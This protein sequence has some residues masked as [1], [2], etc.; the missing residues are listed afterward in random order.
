MITVRALSN[1]LLFWKMFVI[2]HCNGSG[3]RCLREGCVTSLLEKLFGGRPGAVNAIPW[4]RS[5]HGD[6]AKGKSLND[7]SLVDWLHGM[8]DVTA[9]GTYRAALGE[10]HTF[11]ESRSEGSREE[12]GLLSSNG[13]GMRGSLIVPCTSAT[14]L[15][16]SSVP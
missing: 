15:F 13:E 8:R 11:G 3:L 1:P 7:V 4:L 2:F 10:A 9:T 14:W 12:Q 5:H 16:V 6:E